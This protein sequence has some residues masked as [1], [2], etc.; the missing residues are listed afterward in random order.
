MKPAITISNY[1][2]QPATLTIRKGATVTWLNNDDDVHTIKATDGPASFISP[3]LDNGTKFS[4]TFQQAGTYHYVCTVHPYMR[5]V[6]VV[7]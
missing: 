4:F 7:R 3:A 5:G 2:F 1:S 6:I